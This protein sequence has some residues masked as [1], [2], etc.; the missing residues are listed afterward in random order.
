MKTQ[1][2]ERSSS[3]QR[4]LAGGGERAAWQRGRGEDLRTLTVGG[5]KKK[6]L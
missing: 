6:R 1:K 5:E 3:T 2:N 4:C